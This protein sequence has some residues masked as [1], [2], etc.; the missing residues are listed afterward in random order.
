MPT[1]LAPGVYVE[2]VEAGSRPIE[3]VGTAVAAFVGFAA[4]GPFNTATL[5][6]NWGQYVKVFGDFVEDCY[7]AQAVYGYFLNGGGNCYVVRIGGARGD[8]G[9]R[10]ELSAAPKARRRPVPDRGEAAPRSTRRRRQ[11]R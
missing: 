2:E 4:Q 11:R 6:S 9:G 1:Y 7:L 10:A 8:D 5:V 3:G